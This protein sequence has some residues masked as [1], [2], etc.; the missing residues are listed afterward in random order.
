M[1]YTTYNLSNI[2][3]LFSSTKPLLLIAERFLLL[4]FSYYLNAYKCHKVSIS[5]KVENKIQMESN[6]LCYL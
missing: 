2:A 3:F 5:Y 6:T 4:N 1:F